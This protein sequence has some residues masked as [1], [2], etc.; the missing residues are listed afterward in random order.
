MSNCSNPVK[1]LLKIWA[2][3]SMYYLLEMVLQ[4]QYN[5]TKLE[6][7]KQQL[8]EIS[9]NDKVPSGVTADMFI[10]IA[11][12]PLNKTSNLVSKLKLKR[13]LRIILTTNID[14]SDRLINGQFEYIYDFA[15]IQ[16]TIIKIYIK[17][18]DA[19]A[20]LKAI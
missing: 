5:C 15:T 3:M 8:V 1:F 4:D 13:H 17:S 9:A 20:G 11:N 2:M 7:L 18:D 6:T 16:G 14:I 10:N 19:R 12:K